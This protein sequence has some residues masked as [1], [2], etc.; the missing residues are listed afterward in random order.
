MTGDLSAAPVSALSVSD[1]REEIDRLTS[2]IL[3]ADSAYYGDDKPTVSDA[4]YDAMRRRLL[5][6]EKKYP[7]LKRDDSP[8]EKVGAPPSAKFE[9][10]PHS[11]PMLSLD[12]AF[13]EDDVAEFEKRIRKFLGLN[14]SDLLAF[15]AEPKIDGLSL[16]LRYENGELKSGVTRG[17]GSIGENVTSNVLAIAEIPRK[18]LGAPSVLEVRGEVYMTHA[19][20]ERLNDSLR[21]EA[22][23]VQKEPEVFANPRN[24]AAGSLRQL[25][26]TITA[27]RPLHFFA[28]AWG[29]V[30]EELAPTQM[31]ALARLKEFGFSTNALTKRCTSVKELLRCYGEIESKRATLGYD[32]DGVVYKVDQLEFQD[33]LGAVSRHPRW[34]IA[35]KFPA[36]QATTVLLAIEIQVGRTGKLTPVARLKPVTVGGVVVSNATLHNEEEIVRKDI[37]EGDTVIVQRAG[38]VIPQIVGVVIEQRKKGARRFVFPEICPVCGSRAI[39][40][41][42]PS[43]GKADVDRRCTGGLICGAQIVERLKHFVSRKC[44]NIDGLGE[45][46]IASFY[47]SGL[48]L[49]PAHIFGLKRRHERREIDLYTYR[50]KTN[51]EFAR[52]RNGERQPTNNKSI[53]NLF[54]GIDAR[55]NIGFDRFINA[56]G[57]RHIGETNAR[58]F[59]VH[60]GDMETLMA[61]AICAASADSAEKR[62]MLAIDGVGE[63]VAQSVIDFF[64]EP[65]NQSAVRRLLA[66]VTPSPIEGVDADSEVTGKTIVFTGTLETMTR[67]EAKALALSLGAKVSGSVSS[68]TDILVAGPGA[69]SKLKKAQEFGVLVMSESEWRTAA[70]RNM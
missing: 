17:D 56:L 38:D 36:E 31:K 70:N 61:A 63:I 2:V 24:A 46:Q 43:T 19:D 10:A 57:I 66:E 33:R 32:I 30:S 16:S 6:I 68:K 22:T 29:E 67:S 48:V 42:N 54:A 5:L 28:Y 34:A 37:R 49:E 50:K 65:H 55:R 51:G 47:E 27:A 8:S 39:N 3:A 11:E 7:K 25:D 52:N 69:G 45:K 23:A 59:A 1:A 41:V 21:A 58:L 40:E 13:D 4:E 64:S 62:D 26:A 44:F 14:G 60:Y 53:E 18:I 15:T 35:H 9:K 20:F 12:N